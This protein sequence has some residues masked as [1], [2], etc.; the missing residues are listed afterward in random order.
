[1]KKYIK[2]QIKMFKH[3]WDYY[4][5]TRMKLVWMAFVIWFVFAPTVYLILFCVGILT[6]NNPHRFAVDGLSNLS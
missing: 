2:K 4:P 5:E 6:L 3:Q 1:M